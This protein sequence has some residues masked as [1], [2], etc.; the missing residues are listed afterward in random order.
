MKLRIK[1]NF[2]LTNKEI[3]G[4]VN[5][6]LSQLL[7][8]HIINQIDLYIVSVKSKFK[9][10]ILPTDDKEYHPRK[11]RMEIKE[12]ICKI[13]LLRTIAHELAHL[14]QFAK[15]ELVQWSSKVVLWKKIPIDE[16]KINYW[17]Q[18]WEIEAHGLEACLFG[19]Y[20][21]HQRGES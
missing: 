16:S 6:M 20:C 12:N 11:F 7:S 10:T 17:L 5:F 13:E 1:G 2:K 14:K 8:K 18:P 21:E 19:L 3:R 15:N 9:G 4:A